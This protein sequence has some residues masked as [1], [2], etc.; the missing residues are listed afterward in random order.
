MK[1]AVQC[2]NFLLY[3]ARPNVQAIE[4]GSPDMTGWTSPCGA[5]VHVGRKLIFVLDT[6]MAQ[7]D[8]QPHYCREF[9]QTR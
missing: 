8:E 5:A 1:P 4:P 7:R 6:T 3:T 9:N 2:K